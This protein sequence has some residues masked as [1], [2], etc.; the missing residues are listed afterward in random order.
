MMY[1]AAALK[2]FKTDSNCSKSRSCEVKSLKSDSRRWRTGWFYMISFFPESARVNC[3]S[4]RLRAEL[5]CCAAALW[6]LHAAQ[7]CTLSSLTLSPS[8][9]FHLLRFCIADHV[10]LVGGGGTRLGYYRWRCD[11]AV[12]NF[13]THLFNYTCEPRDN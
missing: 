13:K 2:Q 6:C 12:T 4:G 9:S 10:G 7:C 11:G 5:L 8:L 1:D 3:L